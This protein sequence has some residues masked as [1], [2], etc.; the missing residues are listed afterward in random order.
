MIVWGY[1]MLDVI[2]LCCGAGL[3]SA[4]MERA[5]LR[6]ILGIDIDKTALKSYKMN[7]PN[8]M[9]WNEDILNIRSLPKHDITI[10]GVPCVDF[11]TANRNPDIDKGIALL[12]KALE[13]IEISK[14][15]YWVIEEVQGALKHLK[16]KVPRLEKLDFCTLGARNRRP[17][18]LA[19]NFP[20]PVQLYRPVKNPV[21]TVMATEK[22]ISISDMK[23]YQG[24]PEW[25]KLAGNDQSKIRQIGNGVPLQVGVSIGTGII[26][27]DIGRNSTNH[28]EW[29]DTGSSYKRSKEG[30]RQYLPVKNWK[31]CE[32]CQAF[33]LIG[34]MPQFEYKGPGNMN[35]LSSAELNT[36]P[37]RSLDTGL[38]VE[39]N[40]GSGHLRDTMT[41]PGLLSD[42]E[43]SKSD[44]SLKPDISEHANVIISN[45]GL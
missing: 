32:D 39:L 16:G 4:G 25:F 23:Y 40:T 37:G 20:D 6:P 9:I 13:L 35:T 2:D 14:P 8:A 15:R 27:N 42:N 17:R 10:V 19:G 5:G 34:D 7:F 26:Y 44:N 1:S 30:N 21:N 18:I 36:K 3:F 28:K 24:I 31:W 22:D 45:G 12:D 41:A 11:S 33:I 43:K 38:E 29:H